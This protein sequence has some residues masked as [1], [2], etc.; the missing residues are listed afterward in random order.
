[1]AEAAGAAE[2]SVGGMMVAPATDS[3]SLGFA[4]IFTI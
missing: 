2:P 3:N 4:P 1:M